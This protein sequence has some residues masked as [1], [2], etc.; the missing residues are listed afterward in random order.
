MKKQLFCFNVL[1]VSI[2]VVTA[3]LKQVHFGWL[4]LVS[5]GL[6]YAFIGPAIAFLVI[7]KWIRDPF[8]RV[9]EHESGVGEYVDAK[10]GKWEAIGHLVSCPVC[11][12][13]WGIEILTEV[14]LFFP[15]IGR[16]FILLFAAGAVGW[17]VR[18]ITE[19]ACWIAAKNWEET[20]AL[21]KINCPPKPD[22]NSH[23]N[24]NSQEELNQPKRDKEVQYG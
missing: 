7:G 6:A 24:G 22:M 12:G 23:K 14:Y 13:M 15:N 1:F 21:R 19:M 2:V 20:G 3:V 9:V 4:E 10:P 11:A 8:T 17:L 5:L 18:S 16:L